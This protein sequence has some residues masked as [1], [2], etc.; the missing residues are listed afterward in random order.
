MTSWCHFLKLPNCPWLVILILPNCVPTVK[1]IKL[2]ILAAFCGLL[3][4]DSEGRR[5]QE[6]RVLFYG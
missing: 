3:F 2:L 4:E 6:D 5:K 1:T